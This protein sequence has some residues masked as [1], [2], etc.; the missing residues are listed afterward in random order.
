VLTATFDGNVIAERP[1]LAGFEQLE[2][3]HRDGARHRGRGGRRRGGG[4]EGS[5]AFALLSGVTIT[6]RTEGVGDASPAS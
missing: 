1:R 6:E 2:Q 3:A 5:G 4:Q